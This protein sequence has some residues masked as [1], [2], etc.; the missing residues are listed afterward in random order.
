MLSARDVLAWPYAFDLDIMPL[1]KPFDATSLPSMPSS[2]FGFREASE[3]RMPY[4]EVSRAMTY[5]KGNYISN[6]DRNK[7]QEYEE[8][9][10]QKFECLGYKSYALSH[11]VNNYINHIDIEVQ[12]PNTNQVFWVDVESPKALRKRG[13]NK[14]QD[15]M[16]SP[17]DQYVC[18]QLGDKSTLYGGKSDYMAFGLTTGH[19]VIAD[20]EI[21]VKTIEA[22]MSN[23]P[24]T[25]SAWP[26]TALWIP[27]VRSYNDIHTV[28]TYMD[29]ES[30]RPALLWHI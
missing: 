7:G 16:N 10:A 22:K 26:E 28:M 23:I 3:K 24:K 15:S 19:F 18:L 8:A 21:L 6:T 30:L 4:S 5:L 14:P 17:Q 27:Y 11:Y 20:R 1:E 2:I 13:P 29:L 9:C 25:R 12:C